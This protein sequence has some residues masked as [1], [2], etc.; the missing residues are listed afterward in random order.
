MT[1][2]TP[3]CSVPGRR[4]AVRGP[5]WPAQRLGAWRG[6][7]AVLVGLAL[8]A[9]GAQGTPYQPLADEGGFEETRLQ[10]RV[11][12]VSF[13]GNRFTSE[14]DVI[15]F[16]FLR[17]AELTRRHG[18]THFVIEE[19][20][21]R[22]QMTKPPVR[23]GTSLAFGM[24]FSSR[25]SFWGAGI[26]IGPRHYD[27][28]ELAYHLAMFVIRML[29]EEEAAAMGKRAFQADFIVESLAVKKAKSQRKDS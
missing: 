18:H 12:R 4:L 6:A 17:C 16:L 19:D 15:D 13:K 7:A 5:A 23:G 26:G 14:A 22:T 10:E 25:R 3:D 28:P 29:D 9:C 2:N 21:G 27:P 11:Y 1:R 24:G 20:F 8:S